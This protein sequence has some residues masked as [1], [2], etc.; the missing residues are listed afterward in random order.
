MPGKNILLINLYLYILTSIDLD[1]F[2]DQSEL[3]QGNLIFSIYKFR[4]KLITKSIKVI[5][6]MRVRFALNKML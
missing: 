6:Q 5:V 4:L 2:I 1:A 3:E